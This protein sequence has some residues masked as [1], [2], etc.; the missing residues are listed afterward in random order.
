MGPGSMPHLSWPPEAAAARP[1]P[2]PQGCP[3]ALTCSG[4]PN[5]PDMFSRINQ[6][7][8]H[9]GGGRGMRGGGGAG[10]P[11]AGSG[12][13]GGMGTGPA[14]DGRRPR[15][16]WPHFRWR[17]PHLQWARA[18]PPMGAGP[19]SHSMGP[20][21]PPPMAHLRWRGPHLRW[22]GPRLRWRGW[23]RAP[24]PMARAPPPMARAAPPMGV[25]P[26]SDGPTSDGVGYG[27][28]PASDGRGPRLR[29]ARA[30]PAMVRDRTLSEGAPTRYQTV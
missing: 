24:P 9:K 30:P 20:A 25:G 16:R 4:L 12:D 5:C 23:T 21:A 22:R 3:A 18:R 2:L 28:G 14:S 26:A 6:R 19:A 1:L 11:L 8:G 10:G 13:A 29:W 7:D 27:A 17:G 15:P